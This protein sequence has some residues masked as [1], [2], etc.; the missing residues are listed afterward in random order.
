MSLFLCLGALMK[1][2]AVKNEKM[3]SDDELLTSLNKTAI[4]FNEMVNYKYL[5]ISSKKLNG[6]YSYTGY[7]IQYEKSQFAHLCGFKGNESINSVRFFEKCLSKE[8]SP[9]EFDFKES[10]KLASAKL[11][12]CMDL[13]HYEHVKIYKIG[14]KTVGTEKNKF[15]VGIGNDNALMG[16]DERGKYNAMIPVT[17]LKR[18]LREFISEPE[19]VI[20]IIRKKSNEKVRYNDI[21]STAKRGIEINI[22]PEEII[23][24]IDE[25]IISTGLIIKSA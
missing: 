3:M 14:R 23:N 7:E 12:V 5:F 24:K 11:S 1:S 8:L 10:K 2:F 21:V 16:F 22:L 20:A 25:N 18:P 9:I 13:L 6:S 4:L 19:T 15:K 17:V